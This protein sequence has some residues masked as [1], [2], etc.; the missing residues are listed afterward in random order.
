MSISNEDVASILSFVNKLDTSDVQV[1]IMRD[2]S[3]IRNTTVLKRGVYNQLGE[4]VSPGTPKAI[5][6]FDSTSFEPNRLGLAKCCLI[7]K[8]H[9][10]PE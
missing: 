9:C 6:P 5:L 1:M 4:K 7:Q 3:L 10:L 8:T 2:D